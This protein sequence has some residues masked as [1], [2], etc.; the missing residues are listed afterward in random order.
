[1]SEVGT[2][3]G[4]EIVCGPSL[5]AALD[6]DWDQVGQRKEALELVLQVLQAVESWVQTLEQEE[7]ELAQ[8]AL[9]NSNSSERAEDLYE[10]W[11]A[12]DRVSF[13]VQW[14]R[15]FP[16]VHSSWYMLSVGSYRLC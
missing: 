9:E 6:R 8:P 13:P 4:A 15:T 1:M 12:F 14:K 3:V 16:R 2:E 7:K 5:K 11:K 10:G